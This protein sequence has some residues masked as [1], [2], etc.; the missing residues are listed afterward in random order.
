M[1]FLMEESVKG[2]NSAVE[3]TA[4]FFFKFCK[5]IMYLKMQ[6]SQEE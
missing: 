6:I 1:L 5:N 3:F 2:I 4:E